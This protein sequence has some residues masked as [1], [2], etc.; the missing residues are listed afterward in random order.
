MAGT[1]LIYLDPERMKRRGDMPMTG[2]EKLDELLWLL[3]A[4]DHP[5]NAA[6]KLGTNT[7]ALIKLARDYGRM[8]LATRIAAERVRE[9]RGPGQGDRNRTWM[10]AA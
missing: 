5:E 6:R 4:G 3:D 7:N 1:N 10:T 2:G 9:D 8:T